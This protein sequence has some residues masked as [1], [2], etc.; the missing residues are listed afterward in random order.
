MVETFDERFREIQPAAHSFAKSI[1]HHASDAEDSVQN[2]A[3]KAISSFDRYDPSRPFKAWF[4]KILKNCCLDRLRKSQREQT[5]AYEEETSSNH[6]GGSAAEL[7][8]EVE[9]CMARI[10]SAH[11]EILRLR[12]FAEMTYADMADYLEIPNGTVMSRLHAARIAFAD[13]HGEYDD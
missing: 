11:Q 1:L 2:A 6:Q 5:N 4:F 13:Q 7:S 10:S 9:W 3:V 12:Y 8:Q